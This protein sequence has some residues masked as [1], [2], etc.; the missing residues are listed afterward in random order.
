MR[1]ATAPFDIYF[2]GK[3]TLDESLG[4]CTFCPWQLKKVKN[5]DALATHH[6][7]QEASRADSPVTPSAWARR[8][9][10]LRGRD[11]SL[12]G[13]PSSFNLTA[14]PT[15][16]CVN[17]PMPQILGS[18]SV[19][20]D[21]GSSL[22]FRKASTGG[23]ASPKGRQTSPTAIHAG[24]DESRWVRADCGLSMEFRMAVHR[25]VSELAQKRI[26]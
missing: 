11:I 18:L 9:C 6:E 2:W 22:C 10:A 25:T 8:T 19:C 17:P 23:G 4:N 24:F 1:K 20:N 3:P 5:A 14:A 12:L 21:C 15:W 7:D 16:R 13:P 26:F